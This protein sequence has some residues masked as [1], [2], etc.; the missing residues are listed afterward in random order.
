MLQLN[1]PRIARS[2]T[3]GVLARAR[4]HASNVVNVV[5]SLYGHVVSRCDNPAS[6]DVRSLLG[7][8]GNMAWATFRGGRRRVAF[9]YNHKRHVIEARDG[10][11]Q[12]RVIGT[13]QNATSNDQL[14]AFFDAL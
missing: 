7:K 5:P 1:N 2:Y 3:D 11:L 14:A 6:I 4:C 9:V 13:F 12:G 10:S 8:T